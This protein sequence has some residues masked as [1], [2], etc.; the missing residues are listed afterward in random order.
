MKKRLA[1]TFLALCMLFSLVPISA[2]AAG[3]DT[4]A[5][6]V[7][8]APASYVIDTGAKTVTIS[9]A[10]GLAW[11]AKEINSWESKAEDEK[12]SFAGYTINI[13]ADIDLS[14]KLWIPIDAS[15]VKLNGVTDQQKID[16]D[17]SYNNKLLEG[18]TINGNNHKISNMVVKTTVRGPHYESTPGDGQNSYYYAGF[19]GRT[20]GNLTIQD[21]TF[22]GAS[23]DASEEQFV[24]EHGGSSMAVVSGYYS[25][26]TLTLD[27]VTLSDCFVDGMQKVGGYVGQC[28]GS[29]TIDKCAVVDS[30]FRSLYQCAPVI[31]YAMNNQYNNDDGS[32]ASKR[33]NTLTINGIKLENNSVVIV[34]DAETTYK[35]FGDNVDTW[36]YTTSNGYSLWCGN[37]ADTVLIAQDRFSTVSGT[38]D[39]VADMPLTM[40]AEVGGYQYD[41]LSAAAAA[42]K[43]G[44]TI[45]L[46]KDIDLGTNSI[47]IEKSVKI[48]LNGHA[49]TSANAVY[50]LALL[51]NATLMD[52]KGGGAVRNTA[53]QTHQI[54]KNGI[55]LLVSGTAAN[56]TLDNV[57]IEGNYA[58]QMQNSGTAVISNGAIN[59]LAVGI[60]VLG[61]GAANP[62]TSLTINQGTAVTAGIY[63]IS[64]NGQEKYG[65]TVIS[66]TGGTIRQTIED[67][68]AIYHPQDGTLNISGA[69][70]IEG[71]NGIQLCSG[72]G[73][74]A[75]IT[76]GTIRATGSDDRTSKTGD[77]FIPDG[78]ALS[79]VNRNY[80]GGTPKMTVSGGYF[81]SE[82][83][84][85]VLAY[86]WSN[87]QAS[88][89][90]NANEFLTI[91]GGYFTSDPSAYTAEGKTGV[92]SGL[93]DYPYTVGAKGTA[94]VP[95]APP[96]SD[97]NPPK[98]TYPAGSAEKT[99]LDSA[100]T[101]L[102]NDALSA[103][104]TGLQA[105][106]KTQANNN[107]T[108]VTDEIVE[109]LDAAVA[110]DVTAANTHI[111]VQP[112]TE[113]TI[114][115]VDA[116]AGQQSI[117][118]EIQPM[119]R[120]V[121]T[122]VDLE[123]TPDEDIIVDSKDGTVNA[124]VVG[125][126]KPLTVSGPVEITIPL[127]DG[128]TTDGAGLVVKHEKN[129]ALVGYHRTT[130]N[131]VNKTITFTNDKGFSSFTVLAD[132]RSATVQFKDKDGNNI[133]SAETYGPADVNEAL[134]ATAAP[135]GQVFN[136]WT[137]E[138]GS[139]NAI[140]G[141]SGA[142]TTLTDELLTALNGKGTVTATPSFY[143][144]SSG[145]STTY[146]ITVEKAEHGTVTSSHRNA[147]RGV[148]VTLTVKA[149]EGY[150]LD[151]LS[152]TDANG[153]ELK[154]TDKGNGKYT[155]T[156]P[157]AKVTVKAAFKAA[158]HVCPAEKF[159]DVDT[160]AW[161]HEAVDYVLEKGMMQG[162]GSRF[163]PADS[164]SR[165][166]L[167]Q[168]LYNLE[169]K[170]A[171]SASAFEDVSA[172][173]W[174]ADAVAWAS[175]NQVVGG[176]GNGKF[177]PE[178][179][180]TREQM[181]AIL[182]RYAKLK[183]YDTTQGG[184]AV[185]EFT[186]YEQ[187]SDWAGEAMAWAVN[188]K[189]LS[190]KGNHTLDPKGTASRAE[191]AQVLM[192]FGENVSK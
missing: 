142:Y 108:T 80:P 13:T 29:V 47:N 144:P 39:A 65:G 73:V 63:G 38:T 85:A 22:T 60:S 53:Y 155:F 5:D 69:P 139:G 91:S 10:E 169:G 78:A 138:D 106:A 59:G 83:S 134:P 145:G 126:P 158:E 175:A 95:V 88:E 87:N 3:L 148:T 104:G 81:S 19:I 76:G 123:T 54:S 156:M 136:G 26:G 166:M 157:G 184:M 121:A 4:W 180:I 24:E 25:G 167:V 146:A 113:M 120:T 58:I 141:A 130:Y 137:F 191:V 82:K 133:G 17:Q 101:A 151:G 86:T 21:L 116:T 160:G 12:V 84:D 143:T 119:Y 40:T 32:N 112:Y 135:S 77:G 190:G 79:V 129:G 118:L 62:A 68:G 31:A 75:N 6:A 89:W 154:L 186:D 43:T 185:R 93:A 178:D 52:S 23:V 177:G 72:E 102:D 131:S 189:V 42:A 64:G 124:V 55:G 172:Q 35:T 28:G 165:G 153:S 162:S 99:L 173:A 49:I 122:T 61:N 181:A 34:K 1:A 41:T 171:V 66:I 179:S 57:T 48:D 140:E 110:G 192:N 46:L 182:Y 103:E 149:D 45:T 150:E 90:S 100:Q 168:V 114:T 128:F 8:A 183:G 2:M 152:V 147:S 30:T 44:D 97:V 74:I 115:G 174:Y 170:P 117:T 109:E 20:T 98:V 56:V 18:A 161:Y 50:T 9:S 15:T 14:G 27:N 125:E 188:A 107:S 187:I 11:F 92:D 37:Q 127:P 105:A 159:P 51:G 94:V 33:A 16:R 176:Y 163:M 164:L 67:G 132:T 36:Y 71:A 7:M 111:V 70:V 96:A